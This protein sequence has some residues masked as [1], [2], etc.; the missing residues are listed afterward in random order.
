MKGFLIGGG[1]VGML[2]LTITY[3]LMTPLSKLI[4]EGGEGEDWIQAITDFKNRTSGISQQYG[5][6]DWEDMDILPG[7]MPVVYFNQ[8]DPAWGNQY[9]DTR[10]FKKQ[11]IRSG[12]C[13]PTSLAIV[14]SSLSGTVMTPAE[15]A[16]F[17][18]DNGYCAAPQG[19]Y[20]SLFTSGVEKL[21]LTCYYAGDDLETAM[22]YLS[23][24]CLIV[25]LM[26][27]GIFC[28]GGHFVVIRGVTEDGKFLLADC[29][30][31]EN[32]EK[33]WEINTI[34]QNL[35]QDGGGCL[36]VIGIEEREGDSE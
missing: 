28:D 32:N 17:A 10:A 35:K 31:K 5:Y 7:E 3:F 19:S 23:Q 22:G 15:T 9:Y 21:G 4:V 25:S 36:W 16:Q 11:T 18:M 27:P 26:G 14:Y 6:Y 30:N 13:G 34:A 20:R 12:G 24:D 33:E 29:W 2:L 8:A 1:I